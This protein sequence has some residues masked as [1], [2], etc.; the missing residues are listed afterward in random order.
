MI[1]RH[2]FR[3]P[4]AF[5]KPGRGRLFFCLTLLVCVLL[6]APVQAAANAQVSVTATPAVISAGGTSS[7]QVVV[8]DLTGPTSDTGGSS[9]IPLHNA[10]V[11][12][13]TS[14][15]GIT[16]SPSSGTTDAQGRFTSTLTS[17]SS[18]SGTVSVFA[19]AIL[20]R[21][22]YGTGTG[23]VTIRIPAVI[24]PEAD[25]QP[26]AVIQIDH[27]AGTAPLTVQFDG[28][29]SYSP[30]SAVRSYAW[31]FGDGTTGDGYVSA[32]TYTNTGSY[33]A[34]LM[35]TDNA[36]LRSASDSVVIT[37]G[38]SAAASRP[39]AVIVVNQSFGPAPLAVAFDGSKS[40]D[41]TGS[42]QD[43]HWDFGDGSSAH[44]PFTTHRYPTPG[45]YTTTLEVTGADGSLSDFS[46]IQVIVRSSF[47]SPTPAPTLL[48]SPPPT[49]VSETHGMSVNPFVPGSNSSVIF[50]FMP[51]SRYIPPS[52]APLAGIA[53]GIIIGAAASVVTR[54]KPPDPAGRKFQEFVK[55]I[56]G[57]RGVSA[58]TAWEKKKQ[59]IT[60]IKR[61]EIF[62]GL[63]LVEILVA[64]TSA[65]LIGSAF[66]VVNPNPDRFLFTLALFIA[67]GGAVVVLQ[68][69]SRRRV[70]RQHGQYAEYQVWPLGTIIM[71]LTAGFFGCACGKPSRPVYETGR[72]KSTRDAAIEC[73]TGPVLSCIFG[74]LFLVLIPLGGLAAT[75]G[76]VGF[77]MNIVLALYSLMPFEPMDGPKVWAWNRAAYMAIFIPLLV[78]YIGIAYLFR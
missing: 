59:K 78:I 35:V 52:F 3:E 1:L 4:A 16:F 71:F 8:S 18:A 66:Y 17:A 56:L 46:T 6:T 42:I 23:T 70:A 69:L 12:L 44:G 29:Q 20:S 68:D 47:T 5:S 73:L 75:V 62:A 7:I 54:S 11:T 13:S 24:L 65:V 64:I 22:F 31:D 33:T 14:S 58:I 48:Y 21:D 36:G 57:K 32:H 74:C 67:A 2:Y 51:A 38:Q 76:S 55:S 19:V 77:S 40:S 45:S 39:E 41:P 28:R 37:A 30:T 26:V 9:A 72:D 61:K 53:T 34:H 10:Q 25:Q 27:Y 49:L 60:F 15:P 63:S 43:W 50:P